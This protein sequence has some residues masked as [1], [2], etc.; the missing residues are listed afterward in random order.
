MHCVALRSLHENSTPNKEDE[1]IARYPEDEFLKKCDV[2][3]LHV[4]STKYT[5]N[6]LNKER[7]LQMKKGSIVINAGRGDLVD[8][9]ALTEAL[10]TG[11]L[12]AAG[13]DVFCHEPILSEPLRTAKN[14]FILPHLGTATE[15]TRSAMGQRIYETLKAHFIEKQGSLKLEAL[16][17]QVN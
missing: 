5:Q 4:P 15:E 1:N 10:N 13:L 11:H 3:S 9:L 2:I 8:E 12:Y 6:W 17:F 14:I 16:P 7:I